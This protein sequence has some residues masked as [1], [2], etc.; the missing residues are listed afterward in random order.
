MKLSREGKLLIA[1]C[2]VDLMTTL[3]FVHFHGAQEA[4][5]LMRQFLEKSVLLFI[6]AKAAFCLGPLAIIEWA[7]GR[8]P[9]F[10]QG[11]MRAGIFLYLG[12]YGSVVWK[13]NQQSGEPTYTPDEAAQ[14]RAFASMPVHPQ[15]L[16]DLRE[17]VLNHS[18][19]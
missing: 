7:R 16:A 9:A 13:I 6:I 12:F 14:I 3:W 11:A 2:F 10:V 19:E 15:R 17:A 18:P 1:I 4:N 5:P 8:N